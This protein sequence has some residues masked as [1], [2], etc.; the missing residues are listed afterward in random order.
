MWVNRDAHGLC[1]PSHILAFE[2]EHFA[3]LIDGYLDNVNDGFPPS[4]ILGGSFA[5]NES[6]VV[7]NRI[8]E[9]E[10]S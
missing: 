5:I 4:N 6:C 7:L 2:E 9:W 3:N 10:D 8:L 1:C